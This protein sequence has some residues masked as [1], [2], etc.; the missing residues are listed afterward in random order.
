YL[1]QKEAG[2]IEAD[3]DDLT[4]KEDREAEKTGLSSKEEWLRSREEA[5]RQRKL[6]NDLK[7]AEKKISQLE[8][9]NERIQEEINLPENSTDA[10]KLTELSARLEENEEALLKLYEDWENLQIL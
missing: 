7:K 1:E 3:S 9:E 5:A 10:D 8:E 2:N 6:E 4:N